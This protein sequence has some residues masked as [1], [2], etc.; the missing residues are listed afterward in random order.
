MR[1]ASMDC[2]PKDKQCSYDEYDLEE[3][4]KIICSFITRDIA[5]DGTGSRK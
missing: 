2:S 1:D 4:W 3:F 5:K